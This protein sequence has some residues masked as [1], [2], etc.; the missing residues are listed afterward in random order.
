MPTTRS[1]AISRTPRPATSP[2]STARSASVSD[3]EHGDRTSLLASGAVRLRRAATDDGRDRGS[4]G[5]RPPLAM[6]STNS[7]NG[8]DLWMTPTAPGFDRRTDR[9]LVLARRQQ[10]DGGPGRAVKGRTRS[11]DERS[12]RWRSRRTT[13]RIVGGR[14][15]RRS[16]SSSSSQR[17]K[18]LDGVARP[19]QRIG[20]G[21]G[22]DG[23]VVDHHD[24]TGSW[25][26]AVTRVGDDRR[27][28]AT[29]STARMIAPSPLCGL[30]EPSDAPD[31]ER[32]RLVRPA[33][34]WVWM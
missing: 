16:A 24:V 13:G 5:R 34:T 6:A 14:R 2:V 10:H 29:S 8:S 30:V 31:E 3:A 1:A 19:S 26:F 22:D 4:V 15:W 33:S 12:P 17:V 23:V 32:Q 20:E 11:S 28:R 18:D 9:G 21:M 27:R 25:L 7:W